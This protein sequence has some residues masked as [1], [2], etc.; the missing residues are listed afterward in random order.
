MR[1]LTVKGGVKNL[2][3]A[4]NHGAVSE[5]SYLKILI[6]PDC[7]TAALNNVTLRFLTPLSQKVQHPSISLQMLHFN[8]PEPLL[9]N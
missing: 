1:Y 7:E 2:N 4:T 8:F 5:T 3:V 9:F 6:L